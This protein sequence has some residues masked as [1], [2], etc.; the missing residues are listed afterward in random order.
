MPTY[1]WRTGDD[2]VKLHTPPKLQTH[3][4]RNRDMHKW[5]LG[6]QSSGRVRGYSG[7]RQRAE[8]AFSHPSVPRQLKVALFPRQVGCHGHG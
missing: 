1:F 6:R 7:E 2:T 8:N 5:C 4:G 3:E